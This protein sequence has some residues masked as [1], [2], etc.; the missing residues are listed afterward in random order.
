MSR[1]KQLTEP[2][3]NVLSLVL[4]S[5]VDFKLRFLFNKQKIRFGEKGSATTVYVTLKITEKRSS[6]CFSVF[7]IT[8]QRILKCCSL[9]SCSRLLNEMFVDGDLRE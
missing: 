1:N 5:L 9:Q 3:A 2:T 8:A 7:I 4:K 6:G